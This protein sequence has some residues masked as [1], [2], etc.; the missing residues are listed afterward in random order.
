MN[1]QF[2]IAI[3]GVE[4]PRRVEVGATAAIPPEDPDYD[5]VCRTEPNVA[6][7]LQSQNPERGCGYQ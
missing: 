7:L 5:A 2:V 6:G 4:L 3:P 1:W